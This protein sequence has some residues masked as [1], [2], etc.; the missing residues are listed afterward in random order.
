MA[1]VREGIPRTVAAATAVSRVQVLATGGTIAGQAASDV[2]EGYRSG[3]VGVAS[4]LSAVPG[5]RSLARLRGEQLA[6]VGSQDMNDDLWL[7]LAARVNALFAADEADGVVITHGT[8]TAEETGYFLHLVVKS[9]RPIVLTGAMRPSTALSADGPLNLYNAVAVAA[10]PEARG[11]GV[12]VA[13]NDDLHSARDVTKSSTTDVQTFISPGPGLLGTVSYGRI[14]YFRRPTRLHTRESEF[15]IDGIESLPRVDV[16]YAHSNMPA[17]LVRASVA[18]GARGIVMAGMGNGNVSTDAAD[19]LADAAASGVIVVRSTRVVSGDVGRNIE[20]NDDV[21][22]SIAGD[23]LNPQKSR[24]L[25]QLCLAKGMD[26]IAIQNAF[27][28]Y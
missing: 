7:R 15:S 10:D 3:E 22:G 14:R 21:V 17:D 27:Y 19:A 24:A 13:V 8:D 20:M 26:A 2:D 1:T 16:L 11:R 5:L 23:Q 6:Q 28:R 9:D 25:L 4:L 12:I 18:L